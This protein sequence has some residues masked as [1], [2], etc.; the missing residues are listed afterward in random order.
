M[1]EREAGKYGGGGAEVQVV[2]REIGEKISVEDA[3]GVG[4]V[5][6]GQV[7]VVKAPG[8]GFGEMVWSVGEVVV[9]ICYGRQ[10]GGGAVER[11]GGCR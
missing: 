1:R 4:G 9:G 7:V 6:G 11:R 2:H 3:W 5:T 10:G 8:H